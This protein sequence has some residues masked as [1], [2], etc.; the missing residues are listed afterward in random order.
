MQRWFD[1]QRE[2]KAAGERLNGEA[3]RMAARWLSRADREAALADFGLMI[4]EGRDEALAE[5]HAELV[6]LIEGEA[7]AEV[8][9]AV[10]RVMIAA[11]WPARPHRVGAIT[12]RTKTADAAPEAVAA[13]QGVARR[14]LVGGGL[15]RRRLDRLQ[16]RPAAGYDPIFNGSPA[17]APPY[18]LRDED[19]SLTVGEL[20]DRFK[21]EKE[22]RLSPGKVTEYAAL[23]RLLRDAWGED[24]PVRSIGRE[25]CRRIR[26]LVSALPAH[27]TK[28]WPGKSMTAAAELA[29]DKG[30]TPM[31]PATANAYLGRLSTLM[32]WAERE[33][34][35]AKNPAVGLT[36]AAPETDAR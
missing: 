1:Q 5:A 34:Y 19:R 14:A 35:I 23:F 27:A 10:D 25:D 33:E 17:E 6:E 36:V 8:A 3:P 4:G 9:A 22:A 31:D 13:L 21:A 2:R 12:T 32:R 29:R 20:L 24:R 7:G 30:L 11:G 18:A 16:G 26:D 28:R 15:A